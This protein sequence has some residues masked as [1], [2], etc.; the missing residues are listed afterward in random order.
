MSKKN[1]QKKESDENFNQLLIGEKW[2]L[3]SK[4]GAGSFGDIYLGENI[5]LENDDNNKIVIVK[6]EKRKLNKKG[7]L[8]HEYH[9]LLHLA[10]CDGVP[11]VYHYETIFKFNYM[12]MDMEGPN[13]S[14]LFLICKK[15]F[16]EK[17]IGYIML[18]ILPV[19]QY[20][21]GKGIIHRDLK[22]AN[23]VVGKWPHECRKL[24]LLDFGLS[25]Q[26]IIR[27]NGI[28]KH[29][30]MKNPERIP[31]SSLT[32]TVRYASINAHYGDQ[33]R[34][35][36]LHSLGYVILYLLRGGRLPWMGVQADSKE[37]KYKIIL[38]KKENTTPRELCAG[39]DRKFRA[40]MD[41]VKDLT[42]TAKPDYDKLIALF[43]DLVNPNNGQDLELCW[44]K[45]E[46]LEQQWPPPD[47]DS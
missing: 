8:K 38:S 21:H 23:I 36:D 16:D 2:K 3:T 37:E 41:Y 10:R 32:G 4:V 12:I 47:D 44:Q 29:I 1:I 6:R 40:Y 14:D 35:C 45:G 28:K 15:K 39:V 22:P 46:F 18:Q 27:E 31:R 17:T 34:R 9:S 30:P 5:E 26:F 13:L 7:H 20:V 19:F 24:L 33:S 11:N 42:F 43:K 25:K